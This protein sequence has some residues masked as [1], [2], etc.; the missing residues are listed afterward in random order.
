M[1]HFLKKSKL[2]L[3]V[4][5]SS[6]NAIEYSPVVNGIETIP[7]WW[8]VL[9]KQYLFQNDFIPSPTMKT[10]V[11]VQ[12]LYAK[13]IAVPMWSDLAVKVYEKNYTWQFS[14]E[15][16]EAKVHP[17]EQ[18]DGYL[19]DANYGHLKIVSPWLFSTKEDVNWMSID[20]IYNRTDFRSYILANGFLN[21][22][23]QPRVNL[24]LF[25]DISKNYSFIIPFNFPF[26]FT[27]LTEKEVVIH[28]HLV[29][30]EKFDSISQRAT[31]IKFINKYR[32]IQK[33]KKCPFN[34]YF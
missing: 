12:D 18:Y 8:K 29:S 15:H 31:R 6:R 23:N 27:P 24:Q 11:G 25:I 10:C 19:N 17:Q 4:F 3:D 28:R 14:D 13:S 26:L 7:N 20:G 33:T 16:T 32:E 21:F 22:S 9:P 5:T 1:I 34:D 30:Q 2:H